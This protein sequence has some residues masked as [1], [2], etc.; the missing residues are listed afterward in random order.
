MKFVA[1]G[2]SVM[3]GQGL[4]DED[5]FVVKAAKAMAARAG[6][7]FNR[8]TDLQLLAHSGA[9]ISMSDLSADHPA[10]LP[11]PANHDSAARADFLREWRFF[12]APGVEETSFLAKG[13]LPN[14]KLSGEV[15]R[16]FPTVLDQID[17][18]PATNVGQV[19]VVFVSGGANDLDFV[20][21][22]ADNQASLE[23]DQAEIKRILTLRY[24]HL[25][26]RAAAKFPKAL[27]IAIG[28]FPILSNASDINRLKTMA[29]DVQN[30]SQ[31]NRNFNE[32]LQ[33]GHRED[34]HPWYFLGLVESKDVTGY[35]RKAIQYTQNAYY[36]SS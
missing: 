11:L 36:A 8:S 34:Y 21:Y 4:L 22:I 14:E 26:R 20:K 27:I 9:P 6:A 16:D 29:Y 7:V 3:W 10:H 30:I 12:F 32:W 18:F 24:T 15:A 13:N 17:L 1:F 33:E 23:A 28:Y 19:D 31:G 5:K 25:L 35:A 2:D